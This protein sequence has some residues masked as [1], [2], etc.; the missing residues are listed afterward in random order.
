MSKLDD[1]RTA[2]EKAKLDQ[3]RNAANPDGAESKRSARI[4]G[5]MML[6]AGVLFSGAAYVLFVRTSRISPLLSGAGVGL[7]GL[8]L[9]ALVLGK[10]P[11]GSR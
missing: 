7:T 2:F 11:R 6:C 10:L 4:G 3:S 8:G 9:Y 1:V 5:A